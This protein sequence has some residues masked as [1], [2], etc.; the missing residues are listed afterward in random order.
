MTS[1]DKK[2]ILSRLQALCARKE[3][4]ESDMY[5]K[6]LKLVEGDAAAASELLASLVEDRF[7]DD[8]RYASA[9]ARD[10][11]SLDGWGPV[12]IRYQLAAKG[13]RRETIAEAMGDI[14]EEKAESRMRDVIA[15][16]F[17]T[18]RDDPEVRLKLL[19]FALTR[20]YEYDAANRAVNDLLRV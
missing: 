3:Y 7:V 9:F 13:I 8:L 12:K 14:D 16:K 20:G 15:S 17:R 10:K 18:L 5:R 6:A 1:D 2:K 11:A 4:C 19:K